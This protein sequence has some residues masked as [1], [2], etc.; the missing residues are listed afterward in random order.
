[1]LIGIWLSSSSGWGA[2]Q[3]SNFLGTHGPEGQF[4]QHRRSTSHLERVTDL[5]SPSTAA[6]LMNKGDI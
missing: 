2:E 5:K 6:I 3:G 4:P 1:M